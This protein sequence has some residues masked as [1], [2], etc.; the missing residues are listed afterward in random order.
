MRV[1]GGVIVRVLDILKLRSCGLEDSLGSG[2]RVK[3]LGFRVSV[4]G[5]GFWGLGFRV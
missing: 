3:G 4:P 5:V 1:G 2:F